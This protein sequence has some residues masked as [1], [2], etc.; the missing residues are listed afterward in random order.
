M[1]N[2]KLWDRIIEIARMDAKMVDI[3][4]K[5]GKEIKK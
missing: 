3:D 1:M 4:K 5:L 2:L